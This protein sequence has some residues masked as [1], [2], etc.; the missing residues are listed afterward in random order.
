MKPVLNRKTTLDG[1]KLSR[2]TPAI[3]GES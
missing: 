2:K 3:E 1:E